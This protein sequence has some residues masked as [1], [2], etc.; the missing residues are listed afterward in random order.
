MVAIRVS[1]FGGMVPAVDEGLLAPI[2]AALAENTWTYNGNVVGLP[3]LKA[4]YTLFTSTTGKVYR[5]PNNYT[6]SA[7]M[8][9]SRWM[10]FSHP[11]T[12]VVR[13][14][15]FGDTFDRYY[16]ASPVDVPRYMTKA[17]VVAA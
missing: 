11:D 7:H 3:E 16:W 6:D 14:Q 13:S 1:P 9:D 15:V 8:S 10:E 2:N 4:L 17:Q 12:D 5:L